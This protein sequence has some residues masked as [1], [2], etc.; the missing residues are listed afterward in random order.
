MTV[1]CTA[2]LQPPAPITGMCGSSSGVPTLVMPRNGLCSAGISSAVS[3]RGPWTWSCSGTNGGGAVACVAPLAGEGGTAALPSLVTPS[4]GEVPMSQSAPMSGA[5]T[6]L[7]TPHLSASSL[8]PLNGGSAPDMVSSRPFAL[9]PEP[10]ALPPVP[11]PGEMPEAPAMAPDLP[12]G[13]QPL[14]PP[15]VRDTIKPSSALRPSGTDA[16]GHMIPGNHFTL[17]DDVS[18]VSFKSGSENIDPS[19][20]PTLDKLTSM[21]L[22]TGGVR[23]TL[24][25]YAAVGDTTSPREARRL[26]LTR[27]LAV[28]DYL[29]AK[30]VSSSRID[31]RALGA[32]VPSGDPDRVDVKAN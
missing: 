10:S 8:P 4:T 22:S 11:A 32:N 29:T 2:P 19:I 5:S 9:P 24:T 14:Q 18:V 1:S 6:H 13:T 7:V 3:G 23:I 25:A 31:V 15:P 16:Q 17:P 27:A 28:R 26:S 21:L 30:G 12:E 20:T